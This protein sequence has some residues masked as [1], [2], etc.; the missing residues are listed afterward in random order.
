MTAR[1]P[2]RFTGST[3]TRAAL[4][5]LAIVGYIVGGVGIATGVTLFVLS[6]KKDEPKSAYVT[7][8]V[9]SGYG[10]CDGRVLSLGGGREDFL[11]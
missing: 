3:T 6:S 5:T 7:P 4:K 9:G 1:S 2:K 8:Y 11:A 10:G